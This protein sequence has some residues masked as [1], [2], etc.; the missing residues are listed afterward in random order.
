MSFPHLAQLVS[1]CLR[2]APLLLLCVAPG[3]AGAAG[4]TVVTAI[5][6]VKHFIERVGGTRVRALAMI[7]PG[8]SPETYEPSP[9][10]MA[11]VAGAALYVAIGVPYERGW[12]AP[13]A[14]Q[15]PALTIVDCRPVPEASAAAGHAHEDV[16]VW[17]SPREAARI[18]T[19]I[20]EA[21]TAVDP[22]GAADYAAN[23]AVFAATLAA[24]DGEIRATLA[25]AAVTQFLVYHPTWEYFARDY[26]LEQ[27]AIE[28]EGKA[29][30][31]RH[32]VQ[33]IEKARR[34][35]LRTVFVQPQLRPAAAAAVARELGGQVVEIDPLAEDYVAALREV[36]ERLAR[37][38]EPS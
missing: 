11:S 4:V 12:L 23:A 1:R 21:L 10:Q 28:H 17:T 34:D 35:G 24:L 27:I 32:V 6:P 3:R 29:P 36:A 2:F 31:A 9:R 18:A 5:A 14:A 13:L 15:N 33:V 30:T 19:C 8:G 38:R 26:G 20:R 37:S 7:G 25:A 16:H 22:N